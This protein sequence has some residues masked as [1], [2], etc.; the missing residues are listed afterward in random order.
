MKCTYHACHQFAW[1]HC[2]L[3]R[4]GSSQSDLK[5]SHLGSHQS[6]RKITQPY[7][8]GRLL[9]SSKVIY[10]VAV[11]SIRTKRQLIKVRC[12]QYVALAMGEAYFSDGV[13]GSAYSAFAS[14]ISGFLIW[15]AKDDFT[16]H[17]GQGCSFCT[18]LS[19]DL[20]SL[21]DAL[22]STGPSLEPALHP[23]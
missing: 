11:P 21:P 1:K 7:L 9:M 4:C 3:D 16:H 10:C 13:L 23:V 14:P 15:D 19:P 6:D 12:V 22:P 5:E 2:Y 17:L 18:L 8:S 20:W